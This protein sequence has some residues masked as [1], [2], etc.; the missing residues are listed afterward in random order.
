MSEIAEETLAQDYPK[1]YLK[2]IELAETEARAF[3]RVVLHT[4]TLP[5]IFDNP[6][7]AKEATKE[8]SLDVEYG[9]NELISLERQM[10]GP[11]S[12]AFSN[13][14]IL[15]IEAGAKAGYEHRIVVEEGEK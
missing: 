15:A 10:L 14:E 11:L 12:D 3:G 9:L 13:M 5:L 6:E 8:I 7:A 2:G 4:D 1:H